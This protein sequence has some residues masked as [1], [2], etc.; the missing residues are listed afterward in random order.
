M[1]GKHETAH[2]HKTAKVPPPED[3]MAAA[4]AVAD[5]KAELEEKQK[6]AKAA[7]DENARAHDECES[8]RQRF[9]AAT[10]AL[11]KFAADLPPTAAEPKAEAKA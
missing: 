7:A 6:L 11:V 4:Q 1:S 8:V 3:F 5:T 9:D 10:A 2:A